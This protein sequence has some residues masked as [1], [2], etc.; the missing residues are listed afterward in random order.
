MPRDPITLYVGTYAT[1]QSDGIYRLRLDLAT[2]T[3]AEA[4]DPVPA[5]NPSWLVV[6]PSRRFLYAVNETGASRED[7]PGGVSA[8]AVDPASGGLAFLNRQPS[9]GAAPCYLSLDDQGRHLFVANYWGGTAAVFPLGADGRIGPAS[10]TVRHEGANP[11][12]RDPGPHAHSVDLDPANRFAFVADLGLDRVYAYR[13]DAARG[14]L[15]PNDPPFLAL[16]PG[17]G[18]R[19]LAFHPDGRHAY[20]ID[21]LASTL[22]TLDYDPGA[23][24]FTARE[25]LTTLPAGYAGKSSAAEVAVRAD[26]QFVYGSNRGHDSIAIFAVDGATGRLSPLGHEPTRGRTPRHFAI[27]ATGTFLLAANQG[28]D[29]V[30]VFRIDAASG[31]LAPVG[32]PTPVPSPVCLRMVQ[33]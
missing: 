10:A 8:F 13:F 14:R 17:A 23:G 4:G 9:G 11:T 2:G 12:P 21:E 16:P 15:T 33:D 20:L 25:A 24:R 3:L 5:V 19:H 27:D 31:R 26:G 7:A 28:S 30:V 22:T 32:P 6:H 18:P 1:G 29:T